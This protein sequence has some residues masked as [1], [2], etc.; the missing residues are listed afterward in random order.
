MPEEEFNAIMLVKESGAEMSNKLEQRI[1]LKLKQF[2]DDYDLTDMKVNDM[3]ILRAMFQAMISL[4]DYEQFLFKVRT[5]GI[6]PENLLLIEKL[7]RAMTDLRKSISEFQNDLNITRKHRK[8]DHVQSVVAF[9][10]NLKEKARK[11]YQSKMSYIFC[12]K[13]NTL[14]GTA[15]FLFPKSTNR[16]TFTCQQKDK[17]GKACGTK[18]TVLS[19]QLLENKNTNRVEI[20]PE[21]LL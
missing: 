4:E 15:W 10:D 5:E 13:C 8:S 3:D 21:G 14:L 19:S 9:I 17:D 2:S 16:L 20:M 11:F 7:Q 12:P 18:V 1:E 6:S